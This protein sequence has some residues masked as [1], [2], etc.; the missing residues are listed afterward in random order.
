MN[1]RL[2]HEITIALPSEL[3][4]QGQM[5][6]GRVYCKAEFT[7]IEYLHRKGRLAG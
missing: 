2:S 1:P 7:G 6:A 4:A 3:E 5:G